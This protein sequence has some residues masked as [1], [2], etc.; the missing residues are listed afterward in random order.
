MR[1]KEILLDVDQ[2]ICFPQFLDYINEFLGTHYVIDD[3]DVYFIDEAV[4]PKERFSEYL[5][6]VYDKNLY[7]NPYILPGAIETIRRLNEFYR[8]YILSSCINPFDLKN[9]GKLFQDKYEF[10]IRI[11]PFLN[12]KDFIFTSAKHIFQADIMID[13]CLSNLE[14][15]IQEKI[16]FPSY[17]NK[18]IPE[19]D[20]MKKNIIRAGYEWREGWKQ[21][22]NLLLSNVESE[23]KGYSKK[24]TM[25]SSLG[26][27]L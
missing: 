8:I 5:H 3:F 11:L 19:E 2:V 1:K 12:P 4:I 9:S 25:K 16:L 6:F 23:S 21:I 22:E 7:Q 18:N 15:N 27:I 20:L 24:K 14:G 13:D 26:T 10:L 17:H